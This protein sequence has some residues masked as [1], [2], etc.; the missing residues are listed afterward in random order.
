MDSVTEIAMGV[1][2]D[3]VAMDIRVAWS[4]PV[5]QSSPVALPAAT[6]PLTARVIIR[7]FR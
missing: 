7:G 5:S 1:V 4:D 6:T 3:L 2:I